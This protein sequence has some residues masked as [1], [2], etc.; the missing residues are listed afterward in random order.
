MVRVQPSH[1]RGPGSVLGL[2]RSFLGRPL[3]EMLCPVFSGI[4]G[5][6]LVPGKGLTA[7]LFSLRI[8]SCHC[9]GMTGSLGSFQS[10]YPVAHQ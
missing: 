9:P 10:S 6:C 1:H 2:G 8:T 4:L 5:R 7:V 3:S